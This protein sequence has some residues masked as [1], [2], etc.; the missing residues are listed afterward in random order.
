MMFFQHSKAT[1]EV[2]SKKLATQVFPPSNLN[3]GNYGS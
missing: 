2:Q 1:K 3:Y